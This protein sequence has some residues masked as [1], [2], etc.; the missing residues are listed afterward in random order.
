MGGFGGVYTAL[1]L[2]GA[3]R[4]QPVDITLVSRENFFLFTPL[5]HEVATGGIETRH[6]AYPI[7]SRGA[8]DV[9]PSSRRRWRPWA[10]RKTL[11]GG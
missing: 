7:R 6:I 2:E 8:K 1:H 4:K 5:L 9:S 11:W 10:W 3:L